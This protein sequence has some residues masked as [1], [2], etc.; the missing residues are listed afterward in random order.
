MGLATNLLL[1]FLPLA[2]A[3]QAIIHFRHNLDQRTRYRYA[4][5]MG[6]TNFGL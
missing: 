2:I 6:D 3:N 5:F 4:D 1:A